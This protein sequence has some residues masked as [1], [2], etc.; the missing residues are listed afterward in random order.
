MGEDDESGA[1]VWADDDDDDD[2]D[3]L[4]RDGIG[5]AWKMK[6]WILLLLA[7]F[8]WYILSHISTFVAAIKE[9]AET[10]NKAEKAEDRMINLFHFFY[11]YVQ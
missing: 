2:D 9:K 5:T 4:A 11:F 8:W 3:G 10:L 1:D 7:P 6:T